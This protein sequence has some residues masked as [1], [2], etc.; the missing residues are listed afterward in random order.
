MRNGKKVGRDPEY[1]SFYVRKEN[2]MQARKR[3]NHVVIR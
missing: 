1:L 3:K 2:S